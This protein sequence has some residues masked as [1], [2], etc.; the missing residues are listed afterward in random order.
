MTTIAWDGK[1]LAVDSQRTAGDVIEDT[2]TTKLFT[3]CGSYKAATGCG[4]HSN[5][6]SFIKWVKCGC[7]I[8]SFPT[9]KEDANGHGVVINDK[10]EL[11]RFPF[12]GDGVGIKESSTFTDGSGWMLA[13]G[14]LDAGATAEEAVKV[15]IK[16]DVYTGGK[17]Q[18][19]TFNE[20]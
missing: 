9:D 3:D 12:S 4:R 6:L 13:L 17:V 7:L 19:Y 2:C 14:A 8:G 5:L 10:A 1:T 16:R 11:I 15:A 20:G 18:T